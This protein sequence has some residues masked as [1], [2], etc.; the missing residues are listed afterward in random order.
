MANEAGNEEGAS[1]TTQNAEAEKFTSAEDFLTKSPLYVLIRVD[2]FS[3][4]PQI[5]FECSGKCGKETTWVRVY[6]KTLGDVGN[7]PDSSLKSVGYTCFNCHNSQ[8][9]VIYR[10][11]EW[12][13]RTVAYRS[14]GLHPPGIPSTVDVTIALLKVGQYPQPS[15][16]IPKGLEKNLGKD[17]AS[18]YRKSLVCRNNGYGLGAAV[19]VRRVVEDKTNEL[20]EVVAQLAEAQALDTRAVARIRAIGDSTEYQPYEE[21]LKVASA[22]FPDSLKAGSINPLQV[23]YNLVS[24]GIHSLSEEKCIEI[25]DETRVVF[26]Y[27]FS[28]LRAQS[29]EHRA[30]V[31]RIRK[32]T[33]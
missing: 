20:I 14:T 19:Y 6:D 22:V 5:S 23:L 28:N 21:K 3:P 15:I 13:R 27:V 24:E 9:T 30:F 4:P 11:M 18:L 16:E 1:A 33:S 8:L 17:G 29:M 26:E 31:E 2:G 10:V 7:I 32:L 25:A 12:E